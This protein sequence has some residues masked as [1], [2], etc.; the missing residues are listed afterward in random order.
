MNKIA[1]A[2]DRIIG[3]FSVPNV[4]SFDKILKLLLKHDEFTNNDFIKNYQDY[5]G[6]PPIYANY[7]LGTPVYE[8]EV[9]STFQLWE[10]M[11]ANQNTPFLYLVESFGRFTFSL[12]YE[13]EEELKNLMQQENR[14]EIENSF[15]KHINEKILLLVKDAKGYIV[16]NCFHEGHV[17][18]LDIQFLEELLKKY[19]VPKDKFILIYNSFKKL[20]TPFPSYNYD[21]HLSKKS[22]ETFEL[23]K[24]NLLNKNDIYKKLNIFHIPIRRFREHRIKLLEKL[25]VYDNDFIKNNIISY[26]VTMENN[27]IALKIYSKNQNFK[28]YIEQ[29]KNKNIDEYNMNELGGYG[30]ENKDV[31]S[32]SYFTIVCEAYFNENW[33]YISEKTYK[34]IAHQHPFI[35]LGRPYTLRYLRKIGFKTFSPFIDESYDFEINDDKRFEMVY[36]EIIRLNSLSKLELDEMLKSLNDILIFNQNHLI[37]INKDRKLEKMFID[38]INEII[39]DK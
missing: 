12:G 37:E 32:K 2:Y 5:Y 26:D 27:D 4:I 10:D 17:T 11:K 3:N 20:N 8:Y 34:P 25:Y 30:C 39:L 29:S 16:L 22:I 21:T 7:F 38:F 33:N 36:N 23:N 19:N 1:I 24:L 13:T 15:F 31:Y 14:M 18:E 28:N 35:L 9:K 6:K